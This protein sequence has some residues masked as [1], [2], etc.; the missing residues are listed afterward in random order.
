MKRF[1]IRLIFK[2]FEFQEKLCVSCPINLFTL[3]FLVCLAQICNE[4]VLQVQIL[5]TALELVLQVQV[6]NTALE[7]CVGEIEKYSEIV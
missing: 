3:I 1:H 2:I 4:L 6:L 5:N 7:L